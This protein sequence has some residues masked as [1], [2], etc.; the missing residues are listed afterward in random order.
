[1]P[2]RRLVLA[3]LGMWLTLGIVLFV[4]SVRT[5]LGGLHGRAHGSG[6]VH[7]VPIGGIEAIAALL[8]LLPRTLRAGG[9]GLLLTFAIALIGHAAAGEFPIQL[10][11]FAAATVFV[12]VHG[13]VSWRWV[14]GHGRDSTRA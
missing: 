14:L 9:I 3:F 12:M 13:P 1:M 8:F 5:L 10:L 7:L 6:N 4:L 11:L 2:P